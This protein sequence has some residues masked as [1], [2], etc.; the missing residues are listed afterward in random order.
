MINISLLH[1]HSH[2][3]ISILP[4]FLKGILREE[5]WSLPSREGKKWVCCRLRWTMRIILAEKLIKFLIASPTA[6]HILISLDY[7][8]NQLPESIKESINSNYV[9]TEQL[10]LRQHAAHFIRLTVSFYAHSA[11]FRIYLSSSTH[12]AVTCSACIKCVFLLHLLGL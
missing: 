3:L 10:G 8:G 6:L 11:W 4:E 5:A 1:L 12:R 7:Q 9:L 2:D